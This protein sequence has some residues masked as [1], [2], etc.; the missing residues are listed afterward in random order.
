VRLSGWI[1][2]WIVLSG[3]LL[4]GFRSML[5]YVAEHGGVDHTTYTMANDWMDSD[6]R[7]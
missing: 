5:S 6:S 7:C 2:G 1:L 3:A 4:Q